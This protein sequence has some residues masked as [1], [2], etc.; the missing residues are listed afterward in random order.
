[1]QHQNHTM[2]SW[3]FLSKHG[4]DEYI[5]RFAR[6]SGGRITNT[7]DFVYE[8][9]REPIVLRGILKHK[10]MHRCWQD[11][12]RFYYMDTGYFGNTPGPGNPHGWKLWHRIVPNDLQH[13][14][15]QERPDDRWRRLG[16]D[17]QPRR[18]GL[19]VIVAAPDEKPCKFYGIDRAAWLR[20]TVT[21]LQ[22]ITKR[23]IEIRERAAS[24]DQRVHHAPL[25][26]EL[27]SNTHAVVTF[28]SAAAI[29]SI[30]H[31]VPAFVLAPTHAAAPVANRD[32]EQIDDPYWP[33]QDKLHAWVSSLAYGQFH[34]SELDTGKAYRILNE[35]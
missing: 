27:V 12:R 7:D 17:L 16:I 21:T 30:L 28:N 6:G 24:R 9:S 5:N 26:R 1:M 10:I 22:R 14:D 31:G 11:G 8:R 23:P 20:D 34:V 25:S 18:H 29:E 4:E 15:I 19:R 3:I 35:N 32:L 33:D 2:T 13:P